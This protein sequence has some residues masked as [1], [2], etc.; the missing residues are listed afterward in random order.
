MKKSSVMFLWSNFGHV[1]KLWEHS[2]IRQNNKIFVRYSTDIVIKVKMLLLDALPG[3][4][5]FIHLSK[6]NYLCERNRNFV[7]F[8]LLMP[9]EKKCYNSEVYTKIWFWQPEV[10]RDLNQIKFYLHSPKSQFYWIN[11][12]LLELP[13]YHG[14]GVWL[15]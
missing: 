1:K 8:G 4:F 14:E 15:P 13:L 12:P 9:L 3:Y 7:Q 5:L 6:T 2:V 11:F 10:D